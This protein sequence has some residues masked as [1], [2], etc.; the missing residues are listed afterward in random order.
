MKGLR[1]PFVNRSEVL[2]S[3]FPDRD[4]GAVEGEF[5]PEEDGDFDVSAMPGDEIE[6]PGHMMDGLMNKGPTAL[7][8]IIAVERGDRAEWAQKLLARMSWSC[9]ECGEPYRG[10]E[11]NV[12]VISSIRDLAG[13]EISESLLSSSVREPSISVKEGG[14]RVCNFIGVFDFDYLLGEIAEYGYPEGD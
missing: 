7:K 11:P 12:Q 1:L 5:F 2:G 13:G 10:E 4:V 6:L 9:I 14:S 8:E 3:L